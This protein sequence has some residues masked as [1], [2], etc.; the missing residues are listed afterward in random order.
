[1]LKKIEDKKIRKSFVYTE[2]A[3]FIIAIVFMLIYQDSTI[4]GNFTEFNDDDVRYIRSAWTFVE[5]GILTYKDTVSPTVFIMPGLTYSLSL[6]VILFGKMGCIYAFRIFQ[7]FIQMISL[8]LMFLIAKKVFNEKTALIASVIDTLY[9]VEHYAQT[10]ILTEILFKFFF[11]L[12]VYLCMCALEN[13]KKSLY[14]YA[15]CAFSLCCLFR[16]TAACFPV[17][18]IIVWI[19]KKYKI[20]SMIRYTSIVFLVFAV[21]MMPWITRNYNDFGQFILFTKSSGNPFL[22]GTFIDYDKSGGMG[23]DIPYESSDDAIADNQTE[24]NIGIERIKTYAL[25]KPLSYIS[26]YTLGKTFYFWQPFYWKSNIQQYF[27]IIFVIVEHY[28]IL[29]LSV[30][31]VFKAFKEKKRSASFLILFLSI[32]I[33]NISYLPFMTMGRYSYPLMGLVIILS[34]DFINCK[35]NKNVILMKC[36]SIVKKILRL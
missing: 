18:I 31:S 15:G 11:L 14:V 23:V 28:L 24:I 19:I 5:K 8:Y 22:Q 36:N 34:S 30:C 32:V 9:L 6:F 17:V 4:L 7:I 26:W 25:K 13:N 10:L 16:P 3:F 29:I 33:F 21:F 1:M 12:L 2:A 35:Y 27:F 20:T